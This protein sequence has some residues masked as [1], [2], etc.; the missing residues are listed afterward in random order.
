MRIEIDHALCVAILI[1]LFLSFQSGRY[2]SERYFSRRREQ[3]RKE[4]E[5]RQPK[6]L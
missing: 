5:A 2:W 6:A 1:L 4:W 3:R